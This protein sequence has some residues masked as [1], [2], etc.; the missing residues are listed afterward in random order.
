MDA[1]RIIAM[2]IA[3]A[4]L[5]IA[6]G[7]AGAAPKIQDSAA[8]SVEANAGGVVGKAELKA[9]SDEV[10]NR[11]AGDVERIINSKNL[12]G[13]L[14]AVGSSQEARFKNVETAISQQGTPASYVFWSSILTVFILR[15]FD[16][17]DNWMERRTK[18][19]G[20]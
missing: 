6:V 15:G 20:E 5:L 9:L 11:V 13:R 8:E 3:A 1:A 19:K 7:C 12:V 2:V 18:P 17:L 16:S 10:T 14:E 4:V